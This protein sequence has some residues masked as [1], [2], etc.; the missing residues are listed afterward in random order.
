MDRRLVLDK[1]NRIYIKYSNRISLLTHNGNIYALT[2]ILISQVIFLNF[3]YIIGLSL[4]TISLC[5]L[6]SQI[7]ISIIEYYLLSKQNYSK[8]HMLFTI[9]FTINHIVMALFIPFLIWT[10]VL[11]AEK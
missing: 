5:S 10:I 4:T 8:L 7:I 3:H 11:M 9:H 2:T 1:P 6:V